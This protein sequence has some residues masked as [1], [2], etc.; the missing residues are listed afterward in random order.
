MYACTKETGSNMK[1][2]TSRINDREQERYISKMDA[3]K[4]ISRMVNQTEMG[5]INATRLIK[6]SKETGKMDK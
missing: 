1:D 5:Y 6:L 3:G 4:E 2:T